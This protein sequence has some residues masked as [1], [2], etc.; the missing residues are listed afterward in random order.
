MRS[1]SAR[2]IL[3]LLV[4]L[5]DVLR[6]EAPEPGTEVDIAQYL[7]RYTLESIGRTGLGYTFGSL[8]SHG[9]DYSR[10]LKEFG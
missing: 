5:V 7:S 3:T 2:R 9:T 1:L 8:E 6:K 10:A 4:Q